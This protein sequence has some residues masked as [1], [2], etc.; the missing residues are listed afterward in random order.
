MI[1]LG[2]LIASGRR[3]GRVPLRYLL[4]LAAVRLVMVPAGVYLLV[5]SGLTGLPTLAATVLILVAAAPPATNHALIARRYEGDWEL[6][7]SLQLSLHALALVTLPLW[8]SAGLAL[9][10]G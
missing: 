8:L 10:G 5:R 2:G 6:V 4:P 1:I 7:S 9:Q 3:E